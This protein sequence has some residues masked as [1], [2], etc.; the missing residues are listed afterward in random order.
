MTFTS[1][2][3]LDLVSAL[4]NRGLGCGIFQNRMLLIT[5]TT[6]FVVQLTLIYVPF[7]QTVFQTEALR[8]RDLSTLLVLAAISFTLHEMRRRWERKVY[9]STAGVYE[10]GEDVA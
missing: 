3:F 6:S 1:F 7:M 2:V 8:A 5:V 9:G 10:V 4:Q